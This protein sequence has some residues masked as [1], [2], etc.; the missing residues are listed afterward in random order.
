VALA[1]REQWMSSPNGPSKFARYAGIELNQ[2][3][4][5]PLVRQPGLSRHTRLAVVRRR[6]VSAKTI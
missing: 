3:K 6:W 5:L 1:L 2:R 4:A